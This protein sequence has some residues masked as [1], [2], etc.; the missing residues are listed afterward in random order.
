MQ[1]DRAVPGEIAEGSELAF[2]FPLPRRMRVSARF[3]DA[4]HAEGDIPA[5]RLAN[6]VR[7]RVVAEGV[8]TGPAKTV[9]SRATVKTAPQR[10]LRIEVVSRSTETVL[11]IRDQTAPPPPSDP[12]LSQEERWR[13]KGLKPDGSPLDPTR[14]E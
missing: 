9:F 8:E 2:G 6:Y 14:L 4:V 7:Q 13:Q 5:E 10:M 1:V 11:L 3:P 12:G